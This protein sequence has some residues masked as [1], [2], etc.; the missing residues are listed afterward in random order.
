MP[1][2][3]AGSTQRESGCD[4]A[5]E[6]ALR[7]R[8]VLL[9]TPDFVRSYHS[10]NTLP[11]SC[12]QLSF[13]CKKTRRK[14]R[15]GVHCSQQISAAFLQLIQ[16]FSG[17]IC[18]NYSS[19]VTTSGF[20]NFSNY[21][22]DSEYCF[23]P[24]LFYFSLLTRDIFCALLLLLVVFVIIFR[25]FAQSD[26]ADTVAV[27]LRNYYQMCHFCG[28]R[29]KILRLQALFCHLIHNKKCKIVAD[30]FLKTKCFL[31]GFAAFH[32]RIAN[33]KAR[34]AGETPAAQCYPANA[35][36][37]FCCS[38]ELQ[39]LLHQSAIVMVKLFSGVTADHA[40]PRH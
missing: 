9:Y 14:K 34:A 19:A 31:R 35:G 2:S 4:A 33:K 10:R 1:P 30:F 11:S 17:C 40:I 23:H 22:I 12:C 32:F 25:H 3:P 18:R 37:G 36:I 26:F 13:Y 38:S 5:S 16:R 6:T 39:L 15:R 20:L 27:L 29:H 28:I 7:K 21:F 24:L 8:C